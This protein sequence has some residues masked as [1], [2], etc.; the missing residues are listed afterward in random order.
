MIQLTNNFNKIEFESKDGSEMPNWVLVNIKELA[1]DLQVIRDYIKTPIHINSAYRSP[2]HNKKIGGKKNSYHI[3]GMAAD[4][5][6]KGYTPRKLARVI[7]KLIKAGKLE[8][9][10]LGLYNGFIHWDIRGR[11]GR[12]DNSSWYSFI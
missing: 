8:D 5:T 9:G 6:V 11:K 10:G 1:K 2:S 4:I 12:W 3:K 7:L